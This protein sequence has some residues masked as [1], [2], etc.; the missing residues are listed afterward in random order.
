MEAIHVQMLRNYL[1]TAQLQ[2]YVAHQGKVG[3]DWNYHIGK[4][5]I[6][7]LYYFQEG[8]GTIRIRNREYSPQPGQLFL[9]PAD[10]EITLSTDK[11]NTFRK[12]YC[13]FTL[14]VGEVHLFQMFQVPHFVD[15][16]DRAWLNERF[17]KLISL[18]ESHSLTSP[19]Q[20]KSVLYDILTLFLERAQL[21]GIDE[22][23]RIDAVTPAISR[24]NTV[25]SYID[26]HLADRMKIDELADQLHFH[27]KYF[28][29]LFKSS[30]GVSPIVYI[31]KK[32]MEKAQQLLMQ[33][34][35]SIT[36]IASQVG[37]DLYYFSHTFRKFMGLSPTEYR[38]YWK[39]HK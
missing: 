22:D 35:I 17:L 5:K 32:R 20:I 3:P 29:Q 25:L 34:E 24:I 23:W 1:N 19:L 6:N 18:S 37:M 28:I 26:E 4:P 11:A 14:T 10:V 31:T 2:L 9:L 39:N 8:T 27:P 7:R 38:Q 36:D 16:I 21:Q 33:G 15:V 13:H 12:F 30:I